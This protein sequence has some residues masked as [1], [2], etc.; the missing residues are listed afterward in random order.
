MYGPRMR[1]TLLVTIVLSLAACVQHPVL[2]PAAKDVR[3]LVKAE[4][5]TSCKE[6]GDINTG[7]DWFKSEEEVK[8]RLRNRAGDM[9]AN[10]ATLDV[11]KSDGDLVAGSGRAF[12][13]P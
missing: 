12:Q 5:D 11:L 2:S 6:L 13:C 9:R 7:N 10:V 4:P 8:I 1:A 3:L